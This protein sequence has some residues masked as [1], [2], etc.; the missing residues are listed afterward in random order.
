MKRELTQ[1]ELLQEVSRPVKVKFSEGITVSG[2][3][4]SWRVDVGMETEVPEDEAEEAY[5]SLRESVEKKLVD[6]VKENRDSIGALIS[7]AKKKLE[8]NIT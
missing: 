5:N 8:Q 3:Y 2:G 1:K 6:T 4:Q 7:A